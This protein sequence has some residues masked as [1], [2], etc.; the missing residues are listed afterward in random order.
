MF[1]PAPATGLRG[2]APAH[3]HSLVPPCQSKQPLME[4]P[5][6]PLS[7]NAAATSPDPSL[8]QCAGTAPTRSTKWLPWPPSDLTWIFGYF[9]LLLRQNS[10]DRC[11]FGHMMPGAVQSL[12]LLPLRSMVMH[13]WPLMSNLE[14][15]SLTQRGCCPPQ[16][17]VRCHRRPLSQRGSIMHVDS[18]V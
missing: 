4:S 15:R 10:R 6:D 11:S 9:S 8:G 17:S 13:L 7:H 5:R 2:G 16:V 12:L 14:H 1:L 18:G 3:T